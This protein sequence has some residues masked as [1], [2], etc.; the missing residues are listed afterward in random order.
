MHLNIP[1]DDTDTMMKYRDLPKKKIH[2]TPR[3][4]CLCFGAAD[5]LQ[6]HIQSV[7]QV[8]LSCKK[9]HIM[10]A[11]GAA[12]N[13]FAFDIIPDIV[14]TDLDGGEDVLQMCIEHDVVLYVLVHGDN[15]YLIEKYLDLLQAYN[16]IVWCTQGL[17]LYGFENTLGFTD[18]D[19]MLS[20]AILH[21]YQALALGFD[22]NSAVIGHASI[23]AKHF[24][25]NYMKKKLKKLAI[26]KAIAHELTL[27]G[28]L[29]T[30]D[31]SLIDGK[32]TTIEQFLKDC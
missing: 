17:P 8:L 29:F 16:R 25:Q 6:S 11:D 9:P 13:L 22:L 32:E 20:Y 31:Q 14:F 1:N 30:V 24:S 4:K 15:H 2:I 10:A 19:R 3:Q 7:Q 12:A 5:N 18:G 27:S 21:G 26:A 23:R 28:R